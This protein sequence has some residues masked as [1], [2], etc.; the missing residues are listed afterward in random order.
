MQQADIVIEE[1]GN[2]VHVN[3]AKLGG[4]IV[5]HVGLRDKN[6][7]VGAVMMDVE[8]NKPF[9]RAKLNNIKDLMEILLDTL[10][11]S[12]GCHGNIHVTN[13]DDNDAAASRGFLVIDRPLRAESNEAKI[14]QSAMKFLVL[15][16]STLRETIDIFVEGPDP[17]F[18]AWLSKPLQLSYPYLLLKIA[19]KK[20]SLD[21]ELLHLPVESSS[22]V[23]GN[24]LGFETSDR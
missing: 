6:L 10:N 18:F 8:A 16:L 3:K 17:V 12:K 23:E 5:N 2:R 24:A 14:D 9:Y 13:V 11:L 21:I 15:D 1:G 22:K 19:T 20:G 7:L 4:D